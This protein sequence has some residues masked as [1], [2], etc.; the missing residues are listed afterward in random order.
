[1]DLAGILL[2]TVL[3]REGVTNVSHVA[4]MNGS[5][6]PSWSAVTGAFIAGLTYG[7]LSTFPA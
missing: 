5:Y 3:V 2:V 4:V 7:F 1:M 6:I